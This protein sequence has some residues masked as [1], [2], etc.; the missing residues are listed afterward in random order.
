MPAGVALNNATSRSASAGL[1][2]ANWSPHRSAADGTSSRL[3]VFVSR[4]SPVLSFWRGFGRAT[5]TAV[6]VPH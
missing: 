5:G 6:D 1:R 4:N 2:K 3:T